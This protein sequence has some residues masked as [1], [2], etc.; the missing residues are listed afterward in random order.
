MI[1]REVCFAIF[2]GG[3]K[4]YEGRFLINPEKEVSCFGTYRQIEIPGSDHTPGIFEGLWIEHELIEDDVGSVLIKFYEAIETQETSVGW[5]QR[6]AYTAALN[7]GAQSG[8]KEAEAV[9]IGEELK[10][11]FKT[12]EFT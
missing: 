2:S 12:H 10:F 3:E 9:M 11:V 4:R 7:M 1:S 6:V 8:V 5:K